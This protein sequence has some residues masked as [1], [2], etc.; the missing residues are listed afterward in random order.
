MNG[1]RYRWVVLFLCWSVFVMTSVDRASWGPA[2]LPIGESLGVPLAAL[3]VFASTYFIGH[4]LSNAIGG[5]LLDWLGGRSVL[6]VSAMFAGGL[7]VLFGS[8]NSI[9]MGLAI[10]GCL[11]LA[12]GVDFSAGFKFIS[13]WFT[14]ERS[15]LAAGLFTT[16]GTVGIAVAN[17]V[18]PHLIASSGWPTSYRLFGAITIGLGVLCLVFL[19]VPDQHEPRAGAERQARLAVR[20]LLGN[21]N[22]LLLAVVG[23]L[24]FWATGGFATWANTLMIKGV[25]IAPAD[26]GFVLVL[27]SMVSLTTK[28]L[29]GVLIDLRG[30][31]RRTPTALILAAL[32]VVLLLFGTGS[33]YSDFLWFGVALGFTLY[34]YVP[35]L[36]SMVAKFAGPQLAGSAV[37][38]LNAVWQM[39]TM[40]VPTVLGLVFQ[41]SGSFYLAFATL[42]AGP[43]L[44]AV[45]M[46]FV[47]E[48][49]T[50]LPQPNHPA[51]AVPTEHPA[52][53]P[54]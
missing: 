18:V 20:P 49:Q 37:G 9:P 31:G 50:G 1:S 12:A 40:I 24:A 36:G 2:A 39:G 52:K 45:A 21:R 4:I 53:G 16:G 43:L 14:P 6:G 48:K 27:A 26:A 19:R 38:L 29:L 35:L 13:L 8:T 5:V 42:A 28:P 17:S 23:F 22:L 41:A 34:T 54:Q 25:G 3:G 10:Q 30:W 44:A 11:G 46:M 32:G 47:I 7:T 51:P 15:S 33:S